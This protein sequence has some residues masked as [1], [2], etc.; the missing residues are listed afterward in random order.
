MT[1]EHLVTP[2]A[3]AKH[4]YLFNELALVMLRC[5]NEVQLKMLSKPD[6][7]ASSSTKVPA[8]LQL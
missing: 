6:Q 2:K 7:E 1:F 8:Q 3:A 4:E 5:A